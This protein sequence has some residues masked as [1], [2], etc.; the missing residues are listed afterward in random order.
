MRVSLIG[1]AGSGKSYWSRRLA[2]H[3]FTRFCCDEL[4]AEKLAPELAGTGSRPLTMG[5]WMGF[6][7]E[8][9]YEDREARYLVL[10]K[11]MMAEIISY[12]EGHEDNPGENIVVDT[13][14]SVIYTGNENLARL[15]LY[16]TVAYLSISAE[17]REQLL[18][19][20]IANPHPMLW[21]GLFHKEPHETNEEALA[22][23]YPTLVGERERLYEHLSDVTIDFHSRRR[24]GFGVRDFLNAVI[25][26]NS[27]PA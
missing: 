13:T 26:E 3:G 15:R 4:I 10:E 9:G 25:A 24:K 16:T 19:A 14:G 23:C 17:V 18:K 5:E 6:P 27:S 11:E 22:R 1:M 8:A 2:E 20:Y 12:L 7:Y 21:R